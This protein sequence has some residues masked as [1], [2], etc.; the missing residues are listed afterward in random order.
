MINQ[1]LLIAEV[2]KVYSRVRV[3]ESVISQMMGTMKVFIERPIAR[4]TLD[5]LMAK[6]KEEL[7]EC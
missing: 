7:E 1:S 5:E 2:K 4:E 3:L 6:W